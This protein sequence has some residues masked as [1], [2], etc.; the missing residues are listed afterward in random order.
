MTALSIHSSNKQD[1]I[2]RSASFIANTIVASIEKRGECIIGLSGG[3]TPKPVYEALGKM[4]LPW[5]KVKCFLVDERYIASDDPESNQR[6]IKDTL[7]SSAAIPKEHLCF[8]NTALPLS[9]CIEEYA[10]N[11]QVIIA[12]HLPD[13][14]ILGMGEDGHIAS[15]F[16]PVSELALGDQA[17]IIHTTTDTFAIHDRISVSLNLLTASDQQVF[18]LKGEKKK[19]VWESML[20][21]REGDSRWPAKRI[22]KGERVTVIWG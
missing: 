19:K 13:L 18:L 16:P 4:D 3:S 22:L 14:V 21:S 5:D 7:L 20:Q 6:L 1:F 10:R 2:E 15:L 12:D 9:Q 17:L 11:L 8:P